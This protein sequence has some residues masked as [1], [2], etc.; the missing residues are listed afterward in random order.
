MT[1]RIVL[2]NLVISGRHGV[3]PIEKVQPQRFEVDVELELDTSA[4]GRSDDLAR[5]IDYS[6]VERA[7]RNLVESTTFELVEALAERIAT[8]LLAG[9]PL[10]DAAVVRI[11]KPEVRLSGPLDHAGVEITRRRELP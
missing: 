9:Q 7:V 10:A 1:D 3:N 5:T 11:R 8:E 2:S 6:V 4:A